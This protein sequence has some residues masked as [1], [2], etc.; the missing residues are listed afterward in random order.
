[1]NRRH[2]ISSVPSS[3]EE[4]R[5]AIS[6]PTEED[7]WRLIFTSRAALVSLPHLEKSM[8]R[9]RNRQRRIY[10]EIKFP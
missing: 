3:V 7:R 6:L 9:L 5:S 1:M 2:F 4:N 10:D 8:A